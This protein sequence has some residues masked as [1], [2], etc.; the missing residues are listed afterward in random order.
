MEGKGRRGFNIGREKK[1]IKVAGE[2]EAGELER[3]KCKHG[4]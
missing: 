1:K 4:K 2:G 3:N